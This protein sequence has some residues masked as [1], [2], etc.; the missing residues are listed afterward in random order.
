MTPGLSHYTGG[1]S[2]LVGVLCCFVHPF[3]VH[4]SW[5]CCEAGLERDADFC[6]VVKADSF[7]SR[8]RE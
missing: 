2:S 5:V 1:G 8:W 6:L 3:P 7:G 4:I